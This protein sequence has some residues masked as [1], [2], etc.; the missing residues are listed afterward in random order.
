M[1]LFSYRE[2]RYGK[3]TFILVS[4]LII[5]LGGLAIFGGVYAVL[6][7]A[8]WSKYIIVVVACLIGG[9]LALFG[10]FMFF[11]SFSMTGKSKS[12]RDGNEV[13]GISGTRLCDNCG[14]VITKGALVCEHCGAKQHS[15][16]GLKTCPTCKTKN[17][18]AAKFCEK[19]G[20]EF[21]DEQK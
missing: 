6:K 7:M 11:F 10:L 16:L 5:A 2:K 8:H 13:K 20:Y 14:R 3:L 9:L 21:K 18:G 1:G 15:G 17:S 19:C 4:L 12:V